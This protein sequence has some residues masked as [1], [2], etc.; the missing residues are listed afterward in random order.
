M[1][2]HMQIFLIVVVVLIA[3]RSAQVGIA[4]AAEAPE[5]ICVKDHGKG[6]AGL[7]I[8]CYSDAGCAYVE[9]AGGEALRDY[10]QESVPF[11][12]GR[13]KIEGIVTASAKIMKQI[14][15]YGYTCKT[16]D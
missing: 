3:A 4:V 16:V 1:A 12:L 2:K 10:D 5:Q 8:A 11:A 15:A 9:K 6:Y 7:A 13:E 14:K